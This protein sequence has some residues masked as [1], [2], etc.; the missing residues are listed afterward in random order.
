[1]GDQPW[2]IV[3]EGDGDVSERKL[4]NH[5]AGK[6]LDPSVKVVSNVVDNGMRTLVVSR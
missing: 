1:M 6:L 3:V 2:T 5:E 4:G